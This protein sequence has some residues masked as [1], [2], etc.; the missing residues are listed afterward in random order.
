MD[1]LDIFSSVC[2]LEYRYLTSAESNKI[3]KFLSEE[4][5]VQYLARVEVALVTAYATEGLCSAEVVKSVENAAREIH[6]DEVY[7]EEK[8]TRHQMRALVNCLAKKAGNEAGRWIHLGATSHDIVCTADSLRYRDSCTEILIPAMVQLKNTLIHLAMRE[9]D[10]PQIGRTHGQH[11][12]P[13]TF[14]FAIAEYVSRFGTRIVK[15]QEAADNLRG[16]FSGAVGAYNAQ[17]L[18]VSDPIEFEKRFLHILGLRPAEHSTQ[19][20][21][22][23]YVLDLMHIVISAF[24]V[25]ANLA[26]DM[27]HLQRSEIEEVAE[28]F[29]SSQVGSSTMP[30]KRNPIN[31]ENV[32]S[33]W[34]TFVPRIL[35]LYMDQISEHQRDLTNS[36]S[37][38]FYGEILGG[39]YVAMNRL[40]STM[41]KLV[42]DRDALSK[43][44][45]KHWLE[46]R[47]EP[48]YT[49]LALNGYVDA[50]E[51][52]RQ[53]VQSG[54]DLEEFL[55]QKLG[56]T[57]DPHEREVLSE[58]E[59]YLGLSAR[60][61]VSFDEKL[62]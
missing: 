51:M 3:R 38:R 15:L 8:R 13:I 4:A 7:L 44:L 9:K 43:N 14:G 26:D 39:F 48:C 29:S 25:M 40:T 18:I 31:F 60:K 22:P 21:E 37:S 6:A 33:L 49:I 23:E 1:T 54:V 27:R 61:A 36:A 59:H 34:K 5:F 32:K 2:P 47:A 57:L 19:I 20:V 28:E 11:A 46:A 50:H 35:T 45:H 10:T 24:G 12:V 62:E 55:E 42:V 56:R 53:A 17:T 30:H 52:V 16:K 58:P 41:G